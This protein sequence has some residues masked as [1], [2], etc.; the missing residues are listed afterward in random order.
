MRFTRSGLAR[1]PIDFGEAPC[2]ARVPRHE[3][4][5]VLQCAVAR[6]RVGSRGFDLR[7][8]REAESLLCSMASSSRSA[9]IGETIAMTNAMAT[10][11]T[12]WCE[13]FNMPAVCA[14][15]GLAV[16]FSGM[17]GEYGSGNPIAGR[18]GVLASSR[19][20]R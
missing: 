7:I 5:L 16:S 20:R 8:A 17:E 2:I 4:K 19:E 13:F 1:R 11:T 14:A 15:S 10:E 18:G 3:R 9:R 6:D 12:T